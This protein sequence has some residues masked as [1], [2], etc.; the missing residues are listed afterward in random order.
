MLFS[1]VYLLRILVSIIASNTS[2]TLQYKCRLKLCSVRTNS[3]KCFKER[4]CPSVFVFYLPHTA[5]MDPGVTW[6]LTPFNITCSGRVAYTNVTPRISSERDCLNPLRESKRGKGV[7]V[8]FEPHTFFS[9][10][11]TT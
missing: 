5:V 9:L 8:L 6:R 7:A 3:F 2:L 10:V 1:S 4:G 11:S